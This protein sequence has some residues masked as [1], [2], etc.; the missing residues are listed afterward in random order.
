MLTNKLVALEVNEMRK[1]RKY[2]KHF[3]FPV[4]ALIREAVRRYLETV[5]R[6]VEAGKQ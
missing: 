4:N 2:A 1:L 3:G 5:Q 6:E